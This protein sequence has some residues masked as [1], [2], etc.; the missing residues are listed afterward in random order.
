MTNLSNGDT[1]GLSIG[2]GGLLTQ[3]QTFLLPSELRV[4]KKIH[5]KGV[6]NVGID[7]LSIFAVILHTRTHATPHRLVRSRVV[8]IMT[9]TGWCKV[10]ITTV[11]RMLR[12]KNMVK[13]GQ[14]I[15]VG[16]T[17]LWIPAMQFLCQ[18]QHIVGVT[19]FRPV[20]IVD[21]VHASLL[22]GE[23]LATTVASEGQRTLTCDDVPEIDTGIVIGLVGREFC[24]T[25]EAHHLRHL[26]IS[27]H[28]VET[29]LTLRQR[30]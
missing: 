16:K 9:G 27:V 4:D 5:V 25:L 28:I 6:T 22:T 13:R 12:G 3:C 21:E 8:T 14:L 23:V 1:T 15:I 19:G 30:D 17:G 24:N 10:H 20:D 29:V 11:L 26:G 2:E 18:L 7:E